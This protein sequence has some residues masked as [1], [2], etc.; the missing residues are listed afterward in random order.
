MTTERKVN[1]GLFGGR[2]GSGGGEFFFFSFLF[3]S[4]EMDV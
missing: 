3:C 2:C 4:F 1:H